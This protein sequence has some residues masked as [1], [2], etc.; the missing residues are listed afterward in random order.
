MIP[1]GL[2]SISKFICLYFMNIITKIKQCILKYQVPTSYA[3]LAHSVGFCD[4]TG[5]KAEGLS[6]SNNLNCFK[7]VCMVRKKDQDSVF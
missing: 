5:D 1:K 3:I 2:Y 6:G 4:Q 7:K